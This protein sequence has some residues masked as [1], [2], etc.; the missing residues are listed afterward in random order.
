LG[1]RRRRSKTQEHADKQYHIGH[2]E[3]QKVAFGTPLVI[4]RT[5]E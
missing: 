2:G 3:P 1:Q 5:T 4:R